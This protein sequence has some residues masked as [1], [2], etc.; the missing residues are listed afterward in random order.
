MDNQKIWLQLNKMHRDLKMLGYSTL[1][2]DIHENIKNAE[3]EIKI[4]LDKLK[5]KIEGK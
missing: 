5:L 1:G 2:D 3:A 4:T